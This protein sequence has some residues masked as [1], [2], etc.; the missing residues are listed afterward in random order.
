MTPAEL[1]NQIRADIYIHVKSRG[2]RPEIVELTRDE[3]VTL[4]CHS[5]M[6]YWA[7]P[8]IKGCSP[9]TFEGIQISIKE[10]SPD[11]RQVNSNNK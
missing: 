9:K 11:V 7:E 10:T 6:H 2:F 5:E 1:V 3:Y 4:Q 8:D